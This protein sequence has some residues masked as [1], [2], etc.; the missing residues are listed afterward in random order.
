[1][2]CIQNL[3]SY[4]WLNPK[5]SWILP[6]TVKSLWIDSQMGAPESYTPSIQTAPCHLWVCWGPYPSLPLH[7]FHHFNCPGSFEKWLP[8]D[9]TNRG[10]CWE[11]GGQVN[12]RS[13]VLPPSFWL[14]LASLAG[15]RFSVLPYPP[16]GW[17][18]QQSCPQTVG[19]TSSL[20]VTAPVGSFSF[21]YSEKRPPF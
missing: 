9:S 1:M 14:P 19:T 21:L 10:P 4:F 8:A 18:P 6:E 11:V 3:L 16:E 7:W 20:S 2:A 13:W 5:W 12:R 17:L 15:P